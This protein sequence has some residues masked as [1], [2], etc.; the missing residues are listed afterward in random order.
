MVG[1]VLRWHLFKLLV[2]ANCWYG[3]HPLPVIENDDAKLLWDFGM[4][5]DNHV[6]SNRPDIVLFYK[7]E[8]RIIIFKISCPADINEH[9]EKT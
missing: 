9:T 1:W 3:H 5:T 6:T 7:Q 8:R 2:C 4:V